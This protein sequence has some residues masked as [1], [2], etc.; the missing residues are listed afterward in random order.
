MRNALLLIAMQVALTAPVL[1][2]ETLPARPNMHGRD[3]KSLIRRPKVIHVGDP[4]P[5]KYPRLTHDMIL[6]G[7]RGELAWERARMGMNSS[8][9]LTPSSYDQLF[10]RPARKARPKAT[11]P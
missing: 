5:M 9:S 10:T 8:I 4:V 3:Y 11:Q 7:A 2:Q 1:G 6:Q